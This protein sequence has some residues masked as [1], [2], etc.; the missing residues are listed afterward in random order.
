MTS[1]PRALIVDN[2]SDNVASLAQVFEKTG[3]AVET[4]GQL[5]QAREALLKRMPEVAL[6]NERLEG[7]DVMELLEVVELGPIMEIYMMTDEPTVRGATRAMRL[8]ASDYF[9]KPIDT[10]RLVRNLRGVT[11]ELNGRG[12]DRKPEPDARGLLNGE[13]PPM[14]RLYRLIRKCAPSEATVLLVG[15]SGSG[16][17]LAAQTIHELSERADKDFVTLNCSAVAPELIESELFGHKKG[18]FTGAARDHKGYFERASEGT[19]FLDEITE[20]SSKLQAKLLRVL[21][22][23]LVTPIGAETEIPANPRIIAATNRD[24]DEAV[25]SGRLREDLYYRLAQFPIR[26]PALRERG[27]DV[28]LLAAHFLAE[29]NK[30]TGDDKR[31]SEEVLE[32]FRVHDWPGNVRE[33]KNAVVH[34]CLLGDREI[35]VTDLPG[36]IPSQ[37]S[38]RG[39]FIRVAIGTSL[40]EVERRTILATLEHFDGDKKRAA[41][42][43]G[44]SLKTLY[45]RLNSY[46]QKPAA[47]S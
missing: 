18:S 31:F 14:Q 10:E 46:K 27:D 24:P 8:G 39:D 47:A 32:A 34:G 13:S 38:S 23:G 19:L 35:A 44:V 25:S 3:Y 4:A 36:S 6:L 12:E 28:E 26:V 42:V 11:E 37:M 33:L 5:N 30:A 16:K 1:M 41:E 7:E 17:E 2:D 20:M 21:E 29:H 15:E 45:N 9:A 40:A 43:L 22:S